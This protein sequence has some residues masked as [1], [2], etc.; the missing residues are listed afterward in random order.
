[1]G[2]E[3]DQAARE[4]QGWTHDGAAVCNQFGPLFNRVLCSPSSKDGRFARQ[5]ELYPIRTGLPHS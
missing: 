4:C 1:M 2:G 5:F 3:A